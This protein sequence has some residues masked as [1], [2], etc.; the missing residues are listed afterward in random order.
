MFITWE[1]AKCSLEFI[2]S[3]ILQ[4]VV[5]KEQV[6]GYGYDENISIKKSESEFELEVES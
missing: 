1:N 5:P 4:K 6:N 2:F 3:K